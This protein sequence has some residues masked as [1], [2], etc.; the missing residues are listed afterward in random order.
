MP[1][2]DAAVHKPPASSGKPL[3]C[4]E[5][6]VV[7]PETCVEMPVGQDGELWLRGPMVIASYWNDPAATAKGIVAGFWRSGDI[8]CV[9]AEGFVYV[10]DRLKDLINRGG[11]KIYSAEVEAVLSHCPGVLEAAIVG[12]P[13]PVLGERVHAFVSVTSQL[14]EEALAAFC[15]ERL[16]D[17]KVPE[18][19]TL[20]TDPLPRNATGKLS[21]KD[22][23][24]LLLAH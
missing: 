17:Y 8:G 3:A 10:R 4:V 15:A 7:D 21:K 16:G 19:W 18:S 11:Y 12:K 14:T 20:S 5:I 22:L 2:G 24:A 13:D 9:D 23:R 6:L 1:V